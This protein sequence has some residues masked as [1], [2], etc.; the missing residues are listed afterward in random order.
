MSK[1]K[2]EYSLDGLDQKALLNV[3][4]PRKFEIY[5]EEYDEGD[6]GGRRA[7]WY[8]VK[9]N[10]ELGGQNGNPVI[11]IM[12]KSDLVE[13]QATFKQIGQRF[14]I[15]REIDPPTREQILKAA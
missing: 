13:K 4:I 1:E 8:P 10:P 2:N 12:S 14:Q 11:T 5:V 9:N 15:V 6:I 7:G 3:K